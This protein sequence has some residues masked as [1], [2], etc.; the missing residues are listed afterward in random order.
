[1]CVSV[2]AMSTNMWDSVSGQRFTVGVCGRRLQ[3]SRCVCVCVCLCDPV[4]WVCVVWW[5]AGGQ[6]C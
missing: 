6:C 2:W 3:E 4:S 5:C 1:M